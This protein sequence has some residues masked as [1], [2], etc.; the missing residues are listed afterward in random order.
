[1]E[2]VDEEESSTELNLC[3]EE[4]NLV[5][6]EYKKEPLELKGFLSQATSAISIN[7]MRKN[8]P[9]TGCCLPII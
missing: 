4:K 9:L 7:G 1:L 2:L 5:P 6:E 8:M 3:L